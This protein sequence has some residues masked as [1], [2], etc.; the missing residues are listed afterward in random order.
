M[1][2]VAIMKAISDYGIQPSGIM[3]EC[4]FGSMYETVCARF[5]LM[6]APTFPMAA[7]LVFWGGLQNNFW[8]FGHNPTKYARKI[9]CP[10]LLLYGELD[11]KVS[12]AE[13]D[14]ILVN[15]QGKKQLKTYPLAGHENYLNKY[16]SEWK[17]DIA[18][19]LSAF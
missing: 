1:G 5:R 7:L 3:I 6:Q 9:T 19:F 14:E 2:A 4:P 12:R 15:I 16:E 11:D 18:N 17:G 8:A 10:T 13:I